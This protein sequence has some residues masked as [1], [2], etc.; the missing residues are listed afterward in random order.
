MRLLIDLHEDPVKMPA[1][2]AGLHAF[3]PTLPDFSGK[4]RAEALPPIPDRLVADFNPSLVKQALDVP[5]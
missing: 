3:D 4:H 2:T 1:P 5:K